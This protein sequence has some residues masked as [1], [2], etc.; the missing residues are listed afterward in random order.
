MP[1]RAMVHLL[2][3]DRLRFFVTMVLLAMID[4]RLSLLSRHLM[5]AMV[6]LAMIHLVMIL[7]H[8]RRCRRRSRQ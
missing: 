4:F 1:H 3:V 2:M 7:R 5:P 8:K 6:H